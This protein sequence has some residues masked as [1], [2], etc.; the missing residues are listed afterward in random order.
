MV[1][2]KFQSYQGAVEISILDG[3]T[4]RIEHGKRRLRDEHL[5]ANVLHKIALSP[6]SEPFVLLRVIRAEGSHPFNN[7][8]KANEHSSFTRMK[9][10]GE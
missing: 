7:Q 2:L 5:R 9:K 1:L 6:K 4:E 3:R 10:I 8:R